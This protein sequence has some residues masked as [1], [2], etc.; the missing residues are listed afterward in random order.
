M[1][2]VSLSL[3]PEK[4]KFMISSNTLAAKKETP[5]IFANYNNLSG[6]Q[7]ADLLFIPY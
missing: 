2:S 7:S 5:K 3:H 6:S 4:T 1:L